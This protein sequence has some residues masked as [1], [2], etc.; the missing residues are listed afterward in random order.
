MSIIYLC[1]T[2]DEIICVILLPIRYDITDWVVRVDIR[3]ESRHSI[4]QSTESEESIECLTDCFPVSI[5]NTRVKNTRV[6]IARNGS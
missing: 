6:G 1:E 3:R 5:G 2:V 4:V